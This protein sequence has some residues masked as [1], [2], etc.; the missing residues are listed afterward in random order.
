MQSLIPMAN[1]SRVLLA[2]LK[3]YPDGSQDGTVLASL[4]PTQ[5]KDQYVVWSI[6]RTAEDEVD[7]RWEAVWGDYFAS[8]ADAVEHYNLRRS[9]G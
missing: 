9:N 1:G 8:Y 5:S 7:E 3:S 2:D 4:S 6:W